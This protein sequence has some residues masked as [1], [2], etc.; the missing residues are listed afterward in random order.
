MKKFTFPLESVLR[1]KNSLLDEEKNKLNILRT[2]LNRI[3]DAID[4]NSC[5][6]LAKDQE[7]KALANK[8]CGI[9]A[10]R[11]ISFQIENTRRLLEDLK[12]NR[13]KQVQLVEKQL[14]VVIEAKQSVSGM[15]RLKEKHLEHYRE[16]QL[17]ED[18]LIVGE[19]V[20]TKY[21]HAGHSQ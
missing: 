5:Q 1:Y 16:A 14:A 8:G 19:L 12:I 2:E 21:V 15:E 18:A 9:A 10:L 6:L 13:T 3:E 20:S 7:L 4:K 17:K 11:C